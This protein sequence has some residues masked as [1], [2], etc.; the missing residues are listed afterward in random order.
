MRCADQLSKC[1]GERFGA[2]ARANDDEYA[3]VVAKG[4]RQINRALTLHFG[5]IRLFYRADNADDG[6]QLRI[7]Q[8]VAESESLTECTAIR[9]ITPC[10]IFVDDANA[11]RTMRI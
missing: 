8:F 3:V 7:I 4:R 9:P 5:E 11:F 2:L 1:L 6:E 10:Q